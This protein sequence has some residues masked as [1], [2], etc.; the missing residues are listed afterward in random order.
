M[1][2]M[3]KRIEYAVVRNYVIVLIV[4][5]IMCLDVL[6]GQFCTEESHQSIPLQQRDDSSRL[7]LELETCVHR[8]PEQQNFRTKKIFK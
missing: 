1:H 3:W 2:R 4:I 8:E 7:V 5:V 6:N